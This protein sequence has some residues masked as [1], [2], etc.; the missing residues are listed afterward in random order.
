M[1]LS[2]PRLA[3]LP[4]KLC[5][6]VIPTFIQH[7]VLPQKCIC[8]T[9]IISPRLVRTSPA[10]CVLCPL[11]LATFPICGRWWLSR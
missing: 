5:E 11:R 7:F 8:I 10:K 2:E 4:E 1:L 6:N 9:L 3:R